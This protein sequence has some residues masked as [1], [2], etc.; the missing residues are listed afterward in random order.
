MVI[1]VD[2]ELLFEIMQTRAIDVRTFNHKDGVI[3]PIDIRD[4]PNSIRSRQPPVRMRRGVVHDYFS[5][6][7][8]GLEEPE[9]AQRCPETIAIRA[10]M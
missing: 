1:D 7:V 8:E 3:I 9:E 10:D 5:L 6:F 4:H 2:D